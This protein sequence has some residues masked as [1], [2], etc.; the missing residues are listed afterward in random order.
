MPKCKSRLPP[1]LPLRDRRLPLSEVFEAAADGN[2]PKDRS[3]S[4][5][6]PLED[7]SGLFPPASNILSFRALDFALSSDSSS[8]M[9]DMCFAGRLEAMQAQALRPLTYPLRFQLPVARPG[10]LLTRIVPGVPESA[11]EHGA[12]CLHDGTNRKA[13]LIC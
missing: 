7:L 5:D 13:I 8:T 10:S 1:P 3:L 6:R 11:A 9:R 2:A 4:L 12:I